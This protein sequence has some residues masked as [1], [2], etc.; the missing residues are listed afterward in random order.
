MSLMIKF[1]T[2]QT[3]L[4]LLFPYSK[5]PS[6]NPSSPFPLRGWATLGIIPMLA[7]PISARLGASFLTEAR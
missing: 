1:F 6:S 7:D 3:L 5:S 2:P 4:P